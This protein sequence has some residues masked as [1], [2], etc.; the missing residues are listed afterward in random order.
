MKVFPLFY[1]LSFIFAAGHVVAAGLGVSPS[2]LEFSVREGEE[3]SRQLVIYNTG[4]DAAEFSISASSSHIKVFPESGKIAGG[5]AAVSTIT[6]AG[7]KPGLDSGELI[8]SLGSGSSENRIAFALGTA[9]PVSLNV[10]A[11]GAAAANGAIGALVSAG[12]FVAGLAGY[13]RLRRLHLPKA[14]RFI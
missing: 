11:N 13:Y 7:A 8:V 12:T 6:A 10:I 1:F 14:A 4:T 3:A 9:I 2:S 5:K